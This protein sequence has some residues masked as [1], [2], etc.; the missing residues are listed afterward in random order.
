MEP[1]TSFIGHHPDV[2]YL[3]YETDRL[4]YIT[5]EDAKFQYCKAPTD[6]GNFPWYLLAML[7][8]SQIAKSLWMQVNLTLNQMEHIVKTNLIF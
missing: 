7:L 5:T 3:Q 8:L 2:G 4:S 1:L 6:T